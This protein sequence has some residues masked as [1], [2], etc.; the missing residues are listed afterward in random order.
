MASFTEGKEREYQNVIVDMMR[1]EDGLAYTYLGNYQYGKGENAR[2]DGVKN[3]NIIES[4]MRE[5]LKDSGY[6]Q[7]QMDAALHTLREKAA[8][9][10][11]KFADL[12]ERNA[13]FYNLLVAG[14]KAKPSPGKLE[15]DVMFFNFAN[16]EKNRFAFAEEVSYID[17][18]TG[19]HSRPDI[20]VYVNGI[21][22]CVIELKRSLV[23]I[24]EGIRQ[25]LSNERDLIPSFFTT[26]QFTVA[27][28]PKKSRD[29]SENTGF[30]YATVGTPQRFWCNW[31]DDGQK[32]GTQLTDMESFRRF[33]DKETFLFLVRYGIVSD[34][35]VKKVMRPHQFHALHA[36]R[37]RLADKASGVIWHSQGSG[38]S[39]TMAWLANYIRSNFSDPRVLVITDRTELD[40]Q[41][42]RNFQ[43][44]N[45]SPYQ[46]T[47]KVDLLR[48]LNGGT[49]WLICSLIHKFG[50][51]SETEARDRS[52][53]KIPLDKYLQEL[54]EIIHREYP[55]G[56]SV[57]GR[58]LFVFVDECHRTQGGSLHEA[59]KAIMGQDV[60]LIGFTGTPLLK[61][62]KKRGYE[63][64]KNASEVR[65][66]KFIHTYL[67][68]EAVDDGVIL[69]LEYEA[70]DAEQRL[71]SKEQLDT[72]FA[73]LSAGLAPERI[74]GLKDR[75]ATLE[76]VYSANE[77]IE[78][79]GYSILD[80]VTANA[81][82]REDWC[83]AMLVA[84]SI[85][86]AYKYYD[87]FQNRCSN[88]ALKN[89][90]AVV[91]SFSPSDED[92]R[93][94]SSDPHE[95]DELKFKHDMAIKSFADLGVGGV[96][97]YEKKAKERFLNS[98]SQMKLLIVVD[99]L[100]TGFDAPTATVLYIDRDMRNHTLFQ[101]I[102]RVNRLGT[103]VKDKDGKIV[104]LTHKEFGLIID[105][106]HLFDKIEDAVTRFN[107]GAFSGFDEVDIDGLLTDSITRSKVKL[108]AARSAWSALR[109]DWIAR[110]LTDNNLLVEYYKTDFPPDDIA[111]VR[112]QMMYHITQS[113]VA[114]YANL[115]DNMGRAGY[116]SEEASQIHKE[117][118]E[119]RHVNLYVKQNTDDFFDPRL[120][121]PGMRAL[122]DR[123]VRAEEAEVII[124]AT[125]DFSFLDLIGEDGDVDDAA[126]KATNE[127]GSARSAA[128]VIEAKARSVIN[129][130]KDSDPAAFRTYG[131]QLQDILAAIRTETLT[132]Q[133]QMKRLLELIK[134]MKTGEGSYPEGITTKRQR[135]LWNNRS[136]W[137]MDDESEAAAVDTVRV[138][139]EAAEYYAGVNWRDSSSKDAFLFQEELKDRFPGRTEEQIYNLYRYLAQ[140][141]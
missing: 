114:A 94:H 84:D 48:V 14:T 140:N 107:S 3:S 127:A 56:F 130:F 27:A 76:K 80:D 10:S 87:F 135:A 106:K 85:Y 122:L 110:G 124:P 103:D 102:C 120:Y 100:L 69:D 132:F 138:A 126:R 95:E 32:V 2:S 115:A 29:K 60:M 22:L 1:D 17:P 71:D 139:E 19:S 88:T 99:K 50:V 5:H 96:E 57:K 18:M 93:K 23:T 128:E 105:F 53:V 113:V 34:A 92:L 24:D 21:A 55:D 89:R 64:F 30:K 119:A 134:R 49:E 15:K 51:N 68:K 90:C 141:S 43:H 118:C 47:S 9:P 82:L 12:L 33:F 20:V 101:A 108:E 37:D 66:G 25:C 137:M 31:K 42:K 70:R 16:P 79:I 52:S 125:A 63:A 44:T 35:G 77:R 116:S 45:N 109:S 123:F 117:A 13:E 121:D 129:S 26:V 104:T 40:E 41:I 28:N 59:M 83:N 91:T 78:R 86:S 133:E 54:K 39:L 111:K 65:F 38:K 73:A 74:Q 6:T 11:E 61:D 36:C 62:E 136:D 7:M 98:P 112:R 4:E 46:A 72:K 58:N 81:L 97:E 131:E 75:W 67:H 8:L